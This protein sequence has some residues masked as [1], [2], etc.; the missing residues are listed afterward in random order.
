M[1]IVVFAASVWAGEEFQKK[2]PTQECVILVHGLCRSSRSMLKIQ[3]HLEK[4]GYAV[5]NLDY[6]STQK[7]IEAV[8]ETEVARIVR[9]CRR[10]GFKRIHFVTHSLGG[11]V[12]R[13][14]LQDHQLPEGSRVVMLA[15]PSQGSEL[16]DTALAHFPVLYRLGG[17]AA[18]Q[19]STMDEAKIRQWGPVA[20]EL[21]VIAGELSFNPIFS[22]LLPGKDDGKVSVERARLPGM[23]DFIVLPTNHTLILWDNSVGRQILHFLAFGCF[24]R[25]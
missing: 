23:Q 16:A 5:V 10:Q 18:G 13:A 15:P 4:T 24:L 2:L 22:Y 25:R 1:I 19:L 8:A 17:P 9:R 20:V 14:Y 3:K 21:G 7:T 12:V 6:A 11:L